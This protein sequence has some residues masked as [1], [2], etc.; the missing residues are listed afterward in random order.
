MECE[1]KSDIAQLEVAI[2]DTISAVIIRHLSDLSEH[3][4]RLLINF[5]R[6]NNYHFYLQ[7]NK[8]DS[9]HPLYPENPD[10]LFYCIP[11][12]NIKMTF[13][14]EQFTQINSEINLQMIDRAIELLDIKK[15]DRVL[16]LFC[17]ICNFSLP[18]AKY[19][20]QVTGIEGSESA[21]LQAKRNA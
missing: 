15:T 5:A 18:I 7:P 4:L 14:P 13:K 21:I 17:G 19:C 8:V 1:K 10:A 20:A 11:K 12:H 16:D 6:E 3:D 2:G 9:I